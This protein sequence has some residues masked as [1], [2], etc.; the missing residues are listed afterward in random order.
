MKDKIFKVFK[1]CIL[2]KANIKYKNVRTRKYKLDYC[3]KCFTTMLNELN[4]WETLSTPFLIEN[5]HFI[6]YHLI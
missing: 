6:N 4:K 2:E 1:L 3:L 5:A